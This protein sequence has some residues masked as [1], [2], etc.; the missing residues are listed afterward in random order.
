MDEGTQKL[1]DEVVTAAATKAAEIATEKTIAAATEA[2]TKAVEAVKNEI[3]AESAEHSKKTEDSLKL[4]QK[5]IDDMAASTKKNFSIGRKKGSDFGEQLR[6]KAEELKNLSKHSSVTLQL[7][8]FAVADGD[9]RQP[10]SDQAI[11]EI[12]YDPNYQSRVRNLIPSF[13]TGQDGAV[14]YNR[15][16]AETDSTG[17][18]AKGAAQ[19]QSSV[20]LQKKTEEISTVYNLLTIPKEWLS[21]VTGIESYLS[22]RLLG[23]LMDKE[24]DFLI[25]GTGP[26]NNQ[27]TGLNTGALA[28]NKLTTATEA[29]AYFGASWQDQISSPNKFDALT[30]IYA[31]QADNNFKSDLA[32]L[33]YSD[34]YRLG[35]IK[36][37]DNEYALDRT[38]INGVMATFWNGV[39]VVP[40]AAQAAGTYTIVDTSTVGYAIREGVS[41]EFGMNDDDFGTNSVSVRASM[42]GALLNYLPK[43][44]VTGTFSIA[45]TS[46]SNA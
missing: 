37:T 33:S 10:F 18:K 39:R 29:D 26:A 30:A 38:T 2:A 41:I 45:E 35:T 12:K 15:E 42:R 43:G 32:I 40:C 7:K 31:T 36:S 24:D 13:A 3:S 16:T 1:K 23:N 22:Q 11:N 9:A 44:V 5:S 28:A 25:G 8:D 34:Y 20:T 27:F 4:M 17:G 21:D 14:T 46:L 6:E 19:T